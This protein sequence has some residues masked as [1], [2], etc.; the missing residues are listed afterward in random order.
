MSVAD[1][2]PDVSRTPGANEKSIS[3]VAK[4]LRIQFPPDYV[5]LLRWSNGCEG[6]VGKDG[7]IVFWP[8]E[9][10]EKINSEYG[11]FEYAPNV[12]L[13]GTDGGGEG[14]AFDFA[15]N[16]SLF[17]QIP[18][19]SMSPDDIE[20]LADSLTQFLSKATSG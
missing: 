15:D 13:V 7:Y 1:Y 2:L 10:L 11:A 17:V 9:E 8:I 14:Y 4:R 20:P 3:E 6:P 19:A 16:R 5:E 12:I 18:L